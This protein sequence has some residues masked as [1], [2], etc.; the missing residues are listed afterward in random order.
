MFLQ[1]LSQG[2]DQS[3]ESSLDELN[4]EMTFMNDR[5]KSFFREK[6]A[7]ALSRSTVDLSEEDELISL[8]IQGEAQFDQPDFVNYIWPV[9]NERINSKLG[10]Q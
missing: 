3:F 6:V 1:L 8:Q 2:Y 5:I 7:P 4:S 9:I 10:I